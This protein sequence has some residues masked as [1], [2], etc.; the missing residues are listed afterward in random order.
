MEMN[1]AQKSIGAE[2]LLRHVLATLK[3][4]FDIAIAGVNEEYPGF[5]AGNGVRTPVVLVAHMANVLQSAHTA[6]T[7]ELHDRGETGTW[8]EET[9]RFYRI[10]EK[11]DQAVPAGLTQSRETIEKVVQGPL[12]DAMTHIGQLLVIRRMAG[13]PASGANYFKAA[14]KSGK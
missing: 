14:I 8:E 1:G 4:R 10:I 2:D 9:A 11:L 13:D 5:E 7:G 3:F 12:S 6:M